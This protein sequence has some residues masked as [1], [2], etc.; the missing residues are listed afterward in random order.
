MR[1]TGDARI[2]SS[3][4]KSSGNFSGE[5]DQRR[6]G[7]E[8]AE[9]WDTLRRRID[10][11]PTGVDVVVR[12]RRASLRRFLSV[13]AADL[14]APPPAAADPA[15]DGD[16]ERAELRLRFRTPGAARPL[17]AFGADV[18]V[19]SPEVLRTELARIAAETAALYSGGREA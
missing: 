3:P 10:D 11:L 7:V 15:R 19:I 4:E 5:R 17:L 13:Y 6:D 14:S 8:L 2:D 12:I 9:V 16:E 18:E 1:R